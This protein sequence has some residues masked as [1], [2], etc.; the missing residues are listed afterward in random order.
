MIWKEIRN[1]YIETED[2]LSE[3]EQDAE[4]IVCIDAWKTNDD[5]E[6]GEVI[7]KV[8]LCKCGSV[9]VVY[10]NNAARTDEYAQEVINET[11]RNLKGGLL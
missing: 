9:I 1:D 3:H 10:I 5:N 6:E 8:V 11:I 7:A 2:S 4:A